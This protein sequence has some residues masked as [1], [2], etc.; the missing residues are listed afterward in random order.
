MMWNKF[1]SKLKNL[2]LGT[3]R[4][5][6][7]QWIPDKAFIYVVYLIETGKLLRLKQPQT[8]NEKIQW[9]KINDKNH[10]FSTWSDKFLVR[11][12]I[13][14]KIGNDYLIPTIGIY[15]NPDQIN[16]NELPDKFVIKI[17]NGSG[18][19]ILCT[20]KQT[21]DIKS[22][23]RLLQ[24]WMKRNGSMFGREWVYRVHK[25]K[26]IIEEFLEVYDGST[27]KD[28]KF[29]CFNG[30]VKLIQ[31]HNDRFGKHTN[32]FYDIHWNKTYIMQGVPNSNNKEPI[33]KKFSEMV[34]I[35][36]T[37]AKDTKYCR[38]DLY[39]VNDKIYFGEITL[40]PTSGF[41]L[42][43]DNKHDY[44]LGNWIDITR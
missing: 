19:N 37:I 7:F 25:P 16:F 27:P 9:L 43:E 36:E 10:L 4:S 11:E 22:S 13:K 21:F 34:N 20:S 2:I 39:Y 41:C 5:K 44:M 14:Q 29:M 28:Y 3:F 12:F 24:K 32:D 15:E 31:L 23:K 38:V 35:S 6:Y 17:S 26:I 42:F 8:Y 30:K 18:T 40:Y 33:P 1:I